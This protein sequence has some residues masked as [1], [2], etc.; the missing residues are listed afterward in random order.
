MPGRIIA[1]KAELQQ[2]IHD[3]FQIIKDRNSLLQKI[4]DME[5]G[6][7]QSSTDRYYLQLSRAEE[8]LLNGIPP[9]L[10]DLRK[11]CGLSSTKKRRL[12]GSWS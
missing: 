7:R 8:R 10:D 3:V 1:I 5:A 4:R 11:G 9:L 6:G 2:P 12:G